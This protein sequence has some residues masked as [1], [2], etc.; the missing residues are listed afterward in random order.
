MTSALPL[1][2][3]PVLGRQSREAGGGPQRTGQGCDDKGRGFITGVGEVALGWGRAV[4]L[5][6]SEG[7]RAR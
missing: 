6:E 5:V 7:S 3:D 1:S 2:L 4:P